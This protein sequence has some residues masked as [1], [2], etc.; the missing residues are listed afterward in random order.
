MA[1]KFVVAALIVF[2]LVIQCGVLY[3]MENG[4]AEQFSSTWR[5]FG[6]AQT[7]WSAFVFRS[8]SWWWSVPALCALVTG[9]ALWRWSAVMASLA[10]VLG[11]AGAGALLWALYAPALMVHV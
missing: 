5:S 3:A 8:L 11:L 9:Y 10:V 1:K 2:L 7:G 6:V 4:A